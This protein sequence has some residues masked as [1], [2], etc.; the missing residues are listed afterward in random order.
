MPEIPFLSSD[1]P[2]SLRDL[3]D[4]PRSL[5]IEGD[6]DFDS[7]PILAVVGSRASSVASEAWMRRYLPRVSL[8]TAILS[9]GARGIDEVAHRI[10]LSQGRPT[11]VA[12]PSGL[13][14]PYPAHWADLKRDVLRSRGAMISEYPDGVTIRRSHFEKRNR[15]IAALADVVLIVEARLRSGTAIT[16]RHAGQLGRAVGCLPWFPDDPR[17]ELGLSL[18]VNSG[19]QLIRNADEV[20]ALLISQ[21]SARQ[22]RLAVAAELATR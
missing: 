19:A 18:L 11:I 16:A 8:T 21:C 14:N 17:G 4:P 15:L 3:R 10:A 2:S 12:L 20:S 9:G 6:F 7:M 5:F 22:R 13:G 1:F